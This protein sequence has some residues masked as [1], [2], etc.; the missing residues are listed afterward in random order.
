MCGGACMDMNVC[1]SLFI[2][3]A[4][5]P[6]LLRH[7]PARV[8]RVP[9][10]SCAR[11]AALG[12][13]NVQCVSVQCVRGKLLYECKPGHAYTLHCTAVPSAH[14]LLRPLRRGTH[15]DRAERPESTQV[16]A[17]SSRTHAK[18][19]EP[20]LQVSNTHVVYVNVHACIYV[21]HAF[22]HTAR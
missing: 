7:C 1:S 21:S 14:P 19:A 16:G 18:H 22:S 4:A 11:R 6:A 12:V 3:L 20:L 13:Y 9:Q 5:E 17:T 15:A 2:S 8:R 10:A